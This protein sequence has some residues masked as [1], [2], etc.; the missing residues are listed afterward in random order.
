MNTR[1]FI[2]L[3]LFVLAACDNGSVRDTL[4][5]TRSAPDEFRVIARPPL[6]MP[7]EF[8][9]RPPVSA[10]ET[11][12]LGAEASPRKDAQSLL[13]NGDTASINPANAAVQ[14]VQTGA[15]PDVADSQFLKNAHADDASPSIR[16]LLQQESPPPSQAPEKSIIEKLRDPK[17]NEP[18]VDA[19]GE[20]QRLK[21][22]KANGKPLN[23]GETPMES[24]KDRGPLRRLLGY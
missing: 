14:P 23:T 1:I 12:A 11:D 15:L 7:P 8:N 6:S 19:I 20:T 4:G 13:E 22:N 24:E 9:L 17:N 5:L 18:V 3:P 2:L 10:S 21:S 16:T